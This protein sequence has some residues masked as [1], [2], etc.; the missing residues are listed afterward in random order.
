MDDETKRQRVVRKRG[1]DPEIGR[2]DKYKMPP[3]VARC[4]RCKQKPVYYVHT[5][6]Y[7][8]ASPYSKYYCP[9][10]GQ[11]SGTELHTLAGQAHATLLWN[12]VQWKGKMELTALR[13]EGS[14][15]FLAMQAFKGRKMRGKRVG[16]PNFEDVN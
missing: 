7:Q 13:V 2:N 3:E 1:K 15:T 4:H 5:G 16:K 11:N 10:C 14:K 8:G 12:D 6:S 9:E